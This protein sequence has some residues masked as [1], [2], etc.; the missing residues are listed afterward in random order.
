MTGDEYDNFYDGVG[1][2]WGDQITE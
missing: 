2:M 1:G